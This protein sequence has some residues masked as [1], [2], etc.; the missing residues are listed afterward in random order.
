MIFKHLTVG[1]IGTNCYIFGSEKTNEI[2]I[3]DPGAQ[4]DKIIDAAEEVHGKPKAVILT[5]GHFDHSTKVGKIKRHFDIPLMYNKREYDQE[6]FTLKEADKW[7]EEGD[8]ISVGEITL[9]V[10]ETPGHSPGSICLYTTDVKVFDGKKIDGI[11]FTGD[12]LF[13]GSIGR[14]D[15]RGGSLNQLFSSIK[16]KL[17]NNPEITDNFMVFPGHMGMSTIAQERSSN[18][19]RKYF[20]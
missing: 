14:T 9:N 12:L 18:M 1:A 15:I 2:V 8:T 11:V 3:I 7:L 5:H 4:P 16:K 19:F 6:I 17:M 20:T 13:R 10:L